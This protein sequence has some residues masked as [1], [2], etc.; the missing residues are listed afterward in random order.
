MSTNLF[1]FE[2]GVCKY[3]RVYISFPFNMSPLAKKHS[4]ILS[5]AIP[6]KAKKIAG[7]GKGTSHANDSCLHIVRSWC[8]CENH[9]LHSI[10]YDINS[11]S[12]KLCRTGSV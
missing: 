6:R 12:S 4:C 5:L 1:A 8:V 10:L 7:I 2:L 3:S 11:S 9:G